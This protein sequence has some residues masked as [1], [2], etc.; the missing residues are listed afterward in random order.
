MDDIID[1][2]ELAYDTLTSTTPAEA[3]EAARQAVRNAIQG[4]YVGKAAAPIEYIP[5][6][7]NYVTDRAGLDR[8]QAVRRFLTLD[9]ESVRRNP[10]VGMAQL[11]ADGDTAGANQSQTNEDTAAPSRDNAVS[12]S[13]DP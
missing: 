4:K 13:F 1:V 11:P 12:R 10:G 7:I 9:R 6:A 3:A 8:D 5:R 2:V